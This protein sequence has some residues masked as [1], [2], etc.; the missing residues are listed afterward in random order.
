MNALL[1]TVPLAPLLAA[2]IALC[3]A[4]KSPSLCGPIAI[5]ANVVSLIALLMLWGKNTTAETVWLQTGGFTLTAGLQLDGLSRFMALLVA[6]IAL[7]I[8]CYAIEQMAEE[9]GKGWFFAM[10]T[11]FVGAMLAMVL[12]NS[13]VLLF[14]AWEAVGLASFLLIGFWFRKDEAR[15][16]AQRAFLMTRLGDLGLLLAWLLALRFTGNTNIAA[17]LASVGAGNFTG[18]TL[19]LLALLFFAGAIGKSAQLPLTAW[20]PRAMA[21][22]TPVSALIHSAT[23][24]AAGVYLVLRLFALF[25]AAPGALN[26]V[27]WIGAAT[28][29]FSGVV[30]TAQSDLKRVLAWST[31]SQ[32]GEMMFALGLAGPIAAAYH[33]A[34]HAVFKSTLFLAAGAVDHATGTRELKR[35]GKLARALPLT[36]VVFIAAALALAGVWPLSGYWSEDKILAIAAARGPAFAAFLGVVIFVAGVYI[37]RAAVA[38]FFGKHSEEPHAKDAKD[39]QGSSEPL[40]PS[41]ALREAALGGARSPGFIMKS[42][43]IALALAA[44]GLGWALH[45]RIENV[46]AFSA[47]AELGWTWKIIAVGCGLAGLSFGAWRVRSAGPAPALGTFAIVLERSLEVFTRAPAT[48]TFAVARTIAGIESSLDSAACGL[49]RLALT[50]ARLED[51]AE[52]VFDGSARKFVRFA[53]A[54]ANTADQIET[55]GFSCSLDFFANL[56]DRAGARMRGLETGKVYLYTLGLCVWTLLAGLAGFFIWR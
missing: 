2:L 48:V 25:A 36:C 52:A 5:A 3:V 27:L 18:G 24:V 35:L 15:S 56:F 11:F 43:M 38:V 29:L 50:T 41:R 28:A 32:L 45:G 21:G 14:A 13:F 51:G 46:L 16:A 4:K 42:A 47:I 7:P 23:M 17:F 26:V 31:S 34:T 9:K 30:A 49:M 53:L 40:R 8:Q 39:R 33:L 6:A 44:A 55:H 1:L 20:L 19:T 12:S 22:P 37:S 54:S 10:L